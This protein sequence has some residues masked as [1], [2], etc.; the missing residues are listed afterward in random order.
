MFTVAIVGR[1]N[2]G[3]S[4]LF[5]RLVGRR[6]ALVD[7]TPG[8]TRDRRAGR[9]ELGGL[10]FE[11]ID[12]AGLED[13]PGGTLAARMS[14]QTERAVGEADLAL[15]V[16]D[17]RDGAT[18]LDAHFARR[19]RRLATPVILVVNKCEGRGVEARL[20]EFHRLGL[21]NPVA[22]SAEH[23]LGISDLLDV[24]RSHMPPSEPE[25]SDEDG[26]EEGS[27]EQPRALQLAIVG[28]PNV[29]K[30]TLANRLIGSERLLTGP[31]PG[32]TRDAI[33]LDWEYRG[34][35]IHLV[36]TAGLRRH[37]KV[38]DRL[39]HLSAA[40]THNAVRFAELVLLVVEGTDPINRQDLGLARLVLEEGRALVIAANKW[41]AVAY[42]AEA[43]VSLKERIEISLA[44]AKGVSAVPVSAQTGQGIEAMMAA[45]F[46]TYARWNARVS[47]SRLNRFLAEVVEAHPPPL[48]SGRRSK[49][50]FIAQPKSRPPTFALFGNKLDDLPESYLRYLTN[51]MRDAFDLPG[52]PIRLTL[53]PSQNPYDRPGARRK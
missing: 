10:T 12:T 23:G 39:E 6:V 33:G 42:R 25:A 35:A 15:L 17:V 22:I 28:R 38:T 5:N 1:P 21:G 40:S 52:V 43:L 47:T 46:E 26:A 18:S 2:T 37:A 27:E 53:R 41:D 29:G 16:A 19:L 44:Q 13:A 50:R 34:R 36:D 48:T 9:V 45:I 31:E 51:A 20:A 4:T 11:A 3:K 49:I 14:E 8:V 24:V 7:D 30:S 32:I